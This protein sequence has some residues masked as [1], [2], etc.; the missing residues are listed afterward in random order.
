MKCLTYDESQKW[1]GS[2]GVRIDGNR[3]LLLPIRPENVMTTMPK[4]ALALSSFSTRLTDWFPADCGR[5]L[6]LSSW[7]TYPPDQ[8]I[9]FGKIRLGCGESRTPIEAP[10]HLFE[11]S[12]EEGNAVMAGLIFLI[13]AFNWE[14]YIVAA[15]HNDYIF[16]GDEHIVFSS[17][18][19]T[20]MEEASK[21]I[22]D[23]KLEVIT[24]IKNA[25]K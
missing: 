5:L 1:L 22:S 14:A 8:F 10:G 6:W 21:L 18:N 9:I 16:L 25:W 23:Y 3:N 19:K 7:E 13:T 2:M 15:N 12:T 11:S 20:K 24:D 17:A 4:R